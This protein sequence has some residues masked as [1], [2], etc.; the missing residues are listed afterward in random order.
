MKHQLFATLILCTPLVL[1]AQWRSLSPLEQPDTD[2]DKQ[3]VEGQLVAPD[4]WQKLDPSADWRTERPVPVYRELQQSD[5]THGVWFVRVIGSETFLL[6]T[7]V[8]TTGIRAG[9]ENWTWAECSL[10]L[11]R[12][13]T[14]ANKSWLPCREVAQ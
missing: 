6:V 3:I 5:W 2:K 11:E 8:R 14:C 12:S 7:Q 13:R 10:M 9:D 4:E 1:C